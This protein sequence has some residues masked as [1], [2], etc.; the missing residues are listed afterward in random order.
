MKSKA[1]AAAERG[2]SMTEPVC[3]RLDK[4][5]APACPPLSYASATL[6][7][8]DDRRLVVKLRLAGCADVKF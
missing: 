3:R 8:C 5:A 7:L 4:A 2:C 1:R 6:R